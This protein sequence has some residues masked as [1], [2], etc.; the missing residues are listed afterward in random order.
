MNLDGL[1]EHKSS[2][3]KTDKSIQLRW[4]V[5]EATR[6]LYLRLSRIHRAEAAAKFTTASGGI[7]ILDIS[8]S[9][10]SMAHIVSVTSQEREALSDLLLLPFPAFPLGLPPSL[11]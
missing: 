4:I 11:V 2:L 5:D 8:K 10:R 6:L 9:H 7:R 3:G 1:V